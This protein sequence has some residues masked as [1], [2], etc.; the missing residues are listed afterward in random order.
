MG[1]LFNLA[2]NPEQYSKGE[3]VSWMADEVRQRAQHQLYWKAIKTY[4]P[5]HCRSV[6]DIGCSSGWIADKLSELGVTD[7]VGLEPSAKNFAIA[8]QQHPALN[9]LQS[10]LEDY[11]PTQRFDCVLVLM[12]MSHV[13]DV[14]SALHKI[15]S[16]LNLRGVCI[17]VLSRFHTPEQR[18]NRNGRKYEIEEIDSEQYVDRSINGTGFG[19]ADI[20]RSPAYYLRLATKNGFVIEQT[21]FADQG[22]S[23]KLLFVLKKKDHH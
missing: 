14:D 20:N 10:T 11:T 16:F 1:K 7:Y 4:I 19:I 6:L 2:T 5:I 8:H 23:P 21:E 3:A 13:A 17:I 22:Y 18:H 12:V 15:H 9:V